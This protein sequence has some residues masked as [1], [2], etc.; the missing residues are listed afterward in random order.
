VLKEN[1]S[2]F[3]RNKKLEFTYNV[4]LEATDL[5]SKY[6]SSFN[7]N[8]I[9]TSGVRYN[10]NDDETFDD[11]K[12]FASRIRFSIFKNEV[13]LRSLDHLLITL[14]EIDF[15]KYGKQQY[16][17]LLEVILEII[18]AESCEVLGMEH[19]SDDK[20][21]SKHNLHTYD[22]T[23]KLFKDLQSKFKYQSKI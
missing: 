20:F 12:R 10:I 9:N 22:D 1:D 14:N 8:L 7:T 19:D 17:K 6:I 15:K 16:G 3:I 23:Y 18:I 2:D 4:C 13:Y 21:K 5:E 11:V